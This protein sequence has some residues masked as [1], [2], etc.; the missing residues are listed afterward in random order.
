MKSTT[1]L[2]NIHKNIKH[3]RLVA[4]LNQ[5]K[6]ARLLSINR[7]KLAS[8][9]RGHTK[10]PDRDFVRKLALLYGLTLQDLYDK[11]LCH[12]KNLNQVKDKK[13]EIS[14]LGLSLNDHGLKIRKSRKV[15]VSFK[16]STSLFK[17]LL[18]IREQAVVQSTGSANT[19]LNAF[20]VLTDKMLPLSSGAIL[21]TRKVNDPTQLTPNRQ[22]VVQQKKQFFF[23]QLE[24]IQ[25]EGNILQLSTML[26]EDK[27]LHLPLNQIKNIHQ[28]IS[29]IIIGDD[30]KANFFIKKL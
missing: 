5:E 12:E 3:L 27:T 4:D 26:P 10:Q 7:S 18:D 30:R 17:I 15:I 14:P 21:I 13:Q 2:Q 20:E 24:A 25:T 6:F 23:R 28:V 11:D 1:V 22:Y 16:P 29:F 9:E 19:Y 8:Y